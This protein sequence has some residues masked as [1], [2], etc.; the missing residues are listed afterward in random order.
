MADFSKLNGYDVKDK[1]AVRFYDNINDMKSDTTIKND[2]L[3]QTK[4]YANAGDGEGALYEITDVTLPTGKTVIKLDN[5]LYAK[6]IETFNKDIK[7]GT[8]TFLKYYY[9]MTVSY[10][11]HEL[12]RFISVSNNGV[13]WTKACYLPSEAFIC[14]EPY[15][16]SC[17][18]IDDTFYMI[19]DYTDEDFNGYK[20]LNHNY[21]LGGNRVGITKTKDFIN[22]ETYNLDIDLDYKQ[23]WA[24]EWYIEDDDVYVV[25]TM[26][27]CTETY[28]ERDSRTGYVKHC[29]L[30]KLDSDIEE[31]TSLNQ[32]VSSEAGCLIDPFIYKEDNNYYLFI[33]KEPE[34]VI[35][36]YKS[37]N[38]LSFSNLINNDIS[39]CY[40]GSQETLQTQ[41]IE[42]ASVTKIGNF[43]YLICDG[44]GIDGRHREIVFISDDIE[45]WYNAN[46]VNCEE[47]YHMTVLPIDSERKMSLIDKAFQLYGYP[48]NSFPT[49]KMVD[50]INQRIST[51]AKFFVLPNR[52][53][54]AYRAGYTITSI[55]KDLITTNDTVTFINKAGGN[56]ANLLTINKTN[57]EGYYADMVLK[58]GEATTFKGYQSNNRPILTPVSIVNWN[59]TLSYYGRETVQ[60]LVANERKYVELTIPGADYFQVVVAQLTPFMDSAENR[61]VTMSVAKFANNKITIQILSSANINNFSF[62]YYFGI[63]PTLN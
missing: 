25:I 47:M 3:I 34:G 11:T 59:N 49:M 23:T 16:I 10:D 60:N 28:A 63:R 42:G 38:L 31:V 15:D 51:F 53:Y 41:R 7:C 4:G 24:P 50:Y 27:D 61:Q 8:P 57:I 54:V 5:G 20:D 9:Y 46:L 17:T 45:R 36:Q 14:E 29:Y 39:Y 43:Y 26:S 1:K 35:Y 40:N 44:N 56:G 37:D 62:Y 19:Y 33:K 58:Q 48:T 22:F 21:F 55:V 6:R 18:I 32:I 2:M 52:T 12:Q 13:D 30:L